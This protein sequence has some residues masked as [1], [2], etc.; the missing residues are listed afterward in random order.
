MARGDLIRPV[1]GDGRGRR[2]A[3]GLA[4]VSGALLF[5]LVAAAMVVGQ[6]THRAELGAVHEAQAAANVAEGNVATFLA[7]MKAQKTVPKQSDAHALDWN[8]A[9]ELQRDKSVRNWVGSSWV[10]P[11]A[12]DREIKKIAPPHFGSGKDLLAAA[13]GSVGRA[14]KAR[15]TSQR[16][17]QLPQIQP[18]HYFA[19]SA[20]ASGT[21]GTDWSTRDAI[22]EARH[23]VDYVQEAV[24][25]RSATTV[26]PAPAPATARGH[27]KVAHSHKDAPRAR[28]VEAHNT[29][30]V[31]S[32]DSKT[33]EPPKST[34]KSDTVP[35]T[36]LA[37][38]QHLKAQIASL[39]SAIAKVKSA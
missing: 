34:A 29:A 26:Q 25:T 33:V 14:S 38:E 31:H 22:K 36:V 9:P 13:A 35:D 10:Q 3:A 2:R 15:D 5:V 4:A 18:L 39:R 24:N 19:S 6:Q 7:A 11:L 37:K 27:K 21:V 16:M 8:W 30:A 23:S 28:E 1:Q 32:A 12:G 20:S 17:L